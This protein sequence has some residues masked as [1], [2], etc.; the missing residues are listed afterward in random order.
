[1]IAFAFAPAVARAQSPD[2]TIPGGTDYLYTQPGTFGI[3]PP[4]LGTVP[5]VGDPI[6][7]GGSDTVVQR[8]GDADA[9]TGV[10]ITTQLTGLALSGPGG[11][12]VSLDPA[13]LADDMGTMSFLVNSP[14]VPGTEVTGTIT[15][16]LTVYY[17]VTIPGVGSFTGKEDFTST[18][19]WEALLSTTTYPEVTDFKIILDVHVDPSGGQHIVSSFAV[20]EPSTWVMLA[21]AGLIVPAYTLRRGRRRA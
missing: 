17:Q 4:P 16:T 8:N 7:A 5:L 3:F 9:T 21:A 20:P 11:L 14:T 2:I 6:Y 12:T 13:H 15:D 18:G 10:P 19:T 1:M